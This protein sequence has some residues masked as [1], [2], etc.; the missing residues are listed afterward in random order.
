MAKVVTSL[1]PRAFIF[2]NVRGLLTSKWTP[3]GQKGE[4]WEDVQ[5]AFMDIRVRLGGRF[6]SYSISSQLVHAKQYGVPQNR[7]RIIMIGVRDDI[8]IPG[9]LSQVANGLIPDPTDGWPDLVDYL[10]DLADPKWA[11]GGSTDFY[12]S[13]P[14]NLWQQMIRTLSDGRI[15]K[16]GDRLT[17]QEYSNHDPQIIEKFKFMILNDGAIPAEM[18]TKKFAQRVLPKRWAASGPTITATSLAD[19]YVH[20]SL[21]RVPTVREWARLQTFPDWSKFAGKRT[22]GGIRRAGN[23]RENI[24]DREVPKYT[25]I[26]NAVPVALGDEIGKHIANIILKNN[27]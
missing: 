12:I 19:D 13:D 18:Q 15:L 24:F 5:K 26:G 9:N 7:P 16:K 14:Q 6:Q 17:E 25:Q 3:D 1:A 11:P 4:I 2:E 21:P 27:T 8:N 23:P 10:D 20:Y 22:T